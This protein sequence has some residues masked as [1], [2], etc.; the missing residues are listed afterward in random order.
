MTYKLI[1]YFYM[2]FTT[3]M[4]RMLPSYFKCLLVKTEGLFNHS[5]HKSKEET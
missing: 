2:C 5:T 1:I 3:L 4:A